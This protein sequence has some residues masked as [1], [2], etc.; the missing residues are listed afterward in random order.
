MNMD[1]LDTKK[2][3]LAEMIM[4]LRGMLTIRLHFLNIL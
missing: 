1:D 4:K 3:F 2:I